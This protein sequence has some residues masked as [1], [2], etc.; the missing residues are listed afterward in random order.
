VP[1]AIQH[2]C[3]AAVDLFITNDDRLTRA[4]LHGIASLAR[5]PF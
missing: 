3:A 1:D 5:A 4:I 2:A